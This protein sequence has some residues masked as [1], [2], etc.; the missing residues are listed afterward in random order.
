MMDPLTAAH[1]SNR[2]SERSQMHLDTASLSRMLCSAYRRMP[3][4]G[5]PDAPMQ[6]LANLSTALARLPKLPQTRPLAD[7]VAAEFCRRHRQGGALPKPEEVRVRAQTPESLNSGGPQGA[8]GHQHPQRC[9]STHL[10]S[11]ARW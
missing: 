3:Q 5:V 2:C 7:A 1:H 11:C 6:T 10:T 9:M 8:H 4:D